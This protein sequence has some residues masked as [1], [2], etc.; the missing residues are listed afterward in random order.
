MILIH[1]LNFGI[2]RIETMYTVMI[3]SN[4]K[5]SNAICKAYLTPV[6]EGIEMYSGVQALGFLK[7]NP[8]PDLILM[9][10]HMAGMD[11]TEVLKVLKQDE[12]TKDIPVIFTLTEHSDMDIVHKLYMQGATEIITKPVTEIQLLKRIEYQF[13]IKRLREEN[14][15]MKNML[16]QVRLDIEEKF[17]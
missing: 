1:N 13:E 10:L 14:I 2:W 11:G 5:I 12:R 7:S 4:D 3:V 9:D 6:Y 16:E 15:H 17:A 8:L